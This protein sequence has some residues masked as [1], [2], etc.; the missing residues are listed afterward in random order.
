M[1]KREWTL[2]RTRL[3]RVELGCSADAVARVWRFGIEVD[4]GPLHVT[5]ER[6]GRHWPDETQRRCDSPHASSGDDD[7]DW[8]VRH[9]LR[10]AEGGRLAMHYDCELNPENG[11]TTTGDVLL[12]G[13]VMYVHARDAADPFESVE[14]AYAFEFMF[15]PADEAVGDSISPEYMFVGYSS[16]GAD[17]GP[18]DVRAGFFGSAKAADAARAFWAARSARAAAAREKREEE[19]REAEKAEAYAAECAAE[20]VKV[21]VHRVS[22]EHREC[23]DERGR[24]YVNRVVRVLEQKAPPPKRRHWE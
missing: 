21:G 20:A 24:K 22:V 14:K 8:C 6:R 23:V 15:A 13:L 17:A 11:A 10:P 9:V 2:P 7:D 18:D 19:E 1:Q 16:D 4:C 12:A 3:L 5:S